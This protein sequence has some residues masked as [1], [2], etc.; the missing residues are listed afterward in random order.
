M[1]GALRAWAAGR[2]CALFFVGCFGFCFPFACFLLRFFGAGFCEGGGGVMCGCVG[3]R[4]LFLFVCL[5]VCLCVCA[6][7]CVCVCVC[8]CL[9]CV[10]VCARARARARQYLCVP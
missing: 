9:V 3:I 4:F 10:C 8:V 1:T 6:C 5:F 7:V 2:D